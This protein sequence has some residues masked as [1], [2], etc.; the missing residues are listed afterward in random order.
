MGSASEAAQLKELVEQEAALRRLAELAARG[1]AFQELFDAIV[2]EASNFLGSP[3]MT[4][5]QI[6]A[7]GTATMRAVQG[8]V[9]GYVPG[10]RVAI[11]GGGVFERV[12]LSGRPAR[13][14]YREVDTA[15]G[16]KAVSLGITG[17]V[18][19][20]IHV[21]GRLWGALVASAR[22]EPLPNALES[23]LAAFAEL[24]GPAIG[25][26]TARAELLD[27]VDEQAAL[28]RVAELVARGSTQQALFQAVADEASRLVGGEGTTLMRISRD[29]S[30]GVVLATCGAVSTAVGTEEMVQPSDAALVSLI[31]RDRGPA[32]IDE[33]H[34]TALI[35]SGNDPGIASAAGV[36]IILDD[37]VWGVLAAWGLER[38]LPRG[39]E[40]RLAKFAELVAAALANA[41]A[42]A[43]VEA[44]AEEQ[45][46]LRRVA[47]LVARSAQPDDV[48]SVVAR[49]ASLLLREPMT[50]VR[51]DEGDTVI[52]AWAGGAQS[53]SGWSAM[54]NPETL[55]S[56]VRR[57]GHAVRVDHDS[58]AVARP[59]DANGPRSAVAA[60]ISI[61]GRIWGLLVATSFDHALPSGTEQRVAQFAELVAVAIANAESRAAL[62]ASRARV[63]AT[64]DEA[65]RRLQRDV[66][67]GAQQRLVQ[68]VLTLKL[69]SAALSEA[70][71]GVAAELVAE[72][73][74]QAQKAATE[75]GEIVRGILPAALTRGGLR[76]GVESLVADL[77]LAIDLRIDC[78]RLGT[79]LETTAYFVAAE[80]LTNVVK[81]AHANRAA[82]T[83]NI[84]DDRLLVEVHDDGV[85]GVNDARGTGI[86]GLFDRVEAAGGT[87]VV[88]SPPG[89]GTKV[90]ASLRLVPSD[91]G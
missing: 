80:S 34:D 9:P 54:V 48:F 76:A 64:A 14:S 15:P 37:Q 50:L 23:S 87:L 31:I 55:A 42:R 18:G 35:P 91:A 53:D 41:A 57:T 61:A 75:L 21:D 3:L 84:E 7:D 49:E 44:L 29:R 36:P 70:D 73:L 65:R 2:F 56:D 88:T 69:A 10:L 62:S 86:T 63:I 47:E 81:H 43:E 24:L 68:T 33:H 20:P 30:R 5:A 39:V 11:G 13:V 79:D 25:G 83:I 66:H 67:D 16:K 74:D 77:P 52:V 46:A 85:G 60:P 32:R 19:A 28:R 17:A 82:V 71:G 4:L 72:S 22:A 78:E 1:A 51:F 38:E 26:A 45:A 12:S 89:G 6:D 27:L 8:D 59:R 90:R 40:V 58:D